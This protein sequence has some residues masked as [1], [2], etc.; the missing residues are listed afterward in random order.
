MIIIKDFFR[1]YWPDVAVIGGSAAFLTFLFY[2]FF[3][4]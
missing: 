3:W 2:L 1:R 4:R